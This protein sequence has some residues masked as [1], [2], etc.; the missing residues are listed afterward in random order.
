MVKLHPGG[1]AECAR[2]DRRDRA[3]ST[4]RKPLIRFGCRPRGRSRD[5]NTPFSGCD[6]PG[7]WDPSLFRCRPAAA[8]PS[9]NRSHSPPGL[10][11]RPVRRPRKG[12]IRSS[13]HQP[14]PGR[15]QA[16]GGEP[17]QGDQQFPGD[18]HDGPFAGPPVLGHAVGME[19]LGDRAVGLIPDPAPRHLDQMP[20][21]H[22]VA[23][24]PAQASSSRRFRKSR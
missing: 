16:L 8:S 24:S 6:V 9:T 20:A 13:G 23:G 7:G 19:P 3:R 18:R 4:T 17:P 14:G 21:D 1:R 11:R 12:V 15:D 10:L 5:P 2:G 22:R